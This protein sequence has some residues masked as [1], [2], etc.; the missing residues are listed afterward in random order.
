MLHTHDT[1]THSHLHTMASH[2]HN[3]TGY[4]YHADMLNHALSV[5]DDQMA[6][7]HVENPFRLK[8]I[9]ERFKKQGLEDKCLLVSE[10][11]ECSKEMVSDVHPEP[12]FDYVDNLLQPSDS[13]KAI[14]ELYL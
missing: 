9:I 5:D 1:A 8:T 2:A 10:F 11:P 12:Y 13:W 4:V 7:S 6:K 3:D 14:D